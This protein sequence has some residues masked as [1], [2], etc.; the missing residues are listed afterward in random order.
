LSRA[1]ESGTVRFAAVT[2]SAAYQPA[3]VKRRQA[4]IRVLRAV[5]GV[6]GGLFT[7]VVVATV[8]NLLLRSVWPSYAEVEVAMNFT[9]AMLV[10]R[11]LSGALSSLCAG[12]L[13]AWMTKRSRGTVHILA[14]LLV[15][16]FIPVHYKL[17]D[18]FPVWYHLVF[19]FSLVAATIFGAMCY[20]YYPRRKGK[21]L[22]D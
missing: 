6:A 2:L 22:A 20:S 1:G 14:C 4:E 9:P 8:G 5:A 18:R 12:F 16:A 17:W 19:L 3:G 10:M 15:V 21:P 11:L 13:A 7:W